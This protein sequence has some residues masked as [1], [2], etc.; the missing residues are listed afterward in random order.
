MFISFILGISLYW[1]IYEIYWRFFVK[2][3]FEGKVIFITGASSG[4][5]EELAKRFVLLKAKK[6]IISARRREELERVKL[7]CIY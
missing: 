4:I 6:V 5:G 1:L 7:E 2:P 3:T